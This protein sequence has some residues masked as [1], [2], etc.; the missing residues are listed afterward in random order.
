[1]GGPEEDKVRV[2]GLL[3][4]HQAEVEDLLEVEDC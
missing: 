4:D 3:E 1:L 2:E